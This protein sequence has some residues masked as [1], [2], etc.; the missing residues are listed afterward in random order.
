MGLFPQIDTSISMCS[1]GQAGSGR[2]FFGASPP[3]APPQY[4][5]PPS[6]H[7]FPGNVRAEYQLERIFKVI[8]KIILVEFFNGHCTEAHGITVCRAIVSMYREEISPGWKGRENFMVCG[9]YHF[10]TS[11][12]FYHPLVPSISK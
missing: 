8:N 6:L 7:N 9:N 5:L 1:W 3:P 10:N 4:S 11:C 12:S 2:I